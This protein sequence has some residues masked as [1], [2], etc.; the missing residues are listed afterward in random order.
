MQKNLIFCRQIWYHQTMIFTD[1]GIILL[2]Q[3]FRET[4]RIVSLYT[5][6]HGRM[7]VRLPSVCR[8]AGKLK[9]FSEPFVCADYRI[10]LRRGGTIGT[11]TGGKVRS[12]FPRV[13]RDLKRM[14]LAFHFCE[15]MQRLTP[16]HQPSEGKFNL[17]LDALQALETG[18][19]TPAFQ[20]A[21]T[22]RLMTLA[23]FGIDHPVLKITPQFWQQMHEAPFSSLQFSTP[24]ELLS[25]SKCNNVCR[26]FLSQYL[27]YPLRTT[28]PL[29]LQEDWNLPTET[30]AFSKEEIPA[31]AAQEPQIIPA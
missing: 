4:D 9:A 23:G 20:A 11:V 24:D 2:R 15:L 25:L 16:L 8:T 1:T 3:D 7:N 31:A 28:E 13:R 22:L 29:G 26:R 6:T 30:D 5:L 19:V 10:Y 14:T 21:F 12:V 27:T 17:L 18:P